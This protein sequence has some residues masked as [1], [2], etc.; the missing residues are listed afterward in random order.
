MIDILTLMR[1]MRLS[2]WPH[3][4]KLLHVLWVTDHTHTNNT[5]II[6]HI[7]YHGRISLL[8]VRLN[9]NACVAW[10]K[11]RK[12]FGIRLKVSPLPTTSLEFWKCIYHSSFKCLS[13][14]SQIKGFLP[15]VQKTPRAQ[16]SAFD[17]HTRVMSICF[18]HSE[19]NEVW[20]F[21]REILGGYFFQARDVFAPSPC[22][23]KQKFWPRSTALDMIVIH[24][25][26]KLF[27]KSESEI[28]QRHIFFLLFHITYDTVCEWTCF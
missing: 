10:H 2:R 28:F 25:L 20:G 11:K 17:C 21:V 5:L 18:R 14:E 6:I 22:G 13:A 26:L 8:I 3:P 9:S 27:V 23:E 1:H 12:K 4:H 7:D 24:R 16:I 19:L 15:L